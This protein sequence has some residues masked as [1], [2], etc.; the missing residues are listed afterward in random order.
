[1]KNYPWDQTIDQRNKKLN[2]KTKKNCCFKNFLVP[3]VHVFTKLYLLFQNTEK[4]RT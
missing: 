2:E 3:Q 1:M 4:D